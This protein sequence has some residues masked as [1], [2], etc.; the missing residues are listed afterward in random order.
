MKE[1]SL[2]I[3]DDDRE[4]VRRLG[5]YLSRKEESGLRVVCFT[6][7]EKLKA[8][9]L[10][11]KPDGVLAGEN[12]AETE[13]ERDI[14]R[15]FVLSETVSPDRNDDMNV[16]KYQ[17]AEDIF[18]QLM[19]GMEIPGGGKVVL[20][21]QTEICGVYAP[22]GWTESTRLALTLAKKLAREGPALYLGLNEFS[23][24]SSML[25]RDGGRDLSDVAYCWRRGRLNEEKLERMVIHMD[26]YDCIPAPLNPA[27]L[28]E[29]KEKEVK[30]LM[31]TVCRIG[32]YRH[33]VIDFGG[34]I[35]G[36]MNLFGGAGRNFVLFSGTEIGNR[37]QMVY[38]GF[39]KSIGAKELL[40]RSHSVNL[41][42]EDIRGTRRERT[43]E[44]LDELA[45]QL[46]RTDGVFG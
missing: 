16:Y 35:S 19:L 43:E 26:G 18:R 3:C 2:V 28:A 25:G 38:E 11:H 36:R 44:Y 22:S 7:R 6:D 20:C 13:D 5:E 4:Y 10:E 15:R 42:S 39:W 34:S 27:E 37:Q 33:V 17:A 30:E 46:L 8:Y 45:E 31:D 40:A 41:P 23:P 24:V 14:V 1:K 9:L 32:A 12:W 29:L 21:A